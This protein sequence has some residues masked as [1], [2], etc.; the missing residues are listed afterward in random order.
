MQVPII[1]VVVVAVV[2]TVGGIARRYGLPAPLI[3]T[4][5]GIAVSYLPFVGRIELS[6]DLVLVGL[7]A[8]LLYAASL[9]TSLVDFR[10]N[11]RPI[12]LL[13]VGLVLFTAVG[14]GLVVWWL[15]PVSLPAAIAV[16]AVVAPPDAVAATAI[17]RR[18]GMP[19]R[20]VTILEGESLVNDATA[21][22]VLRTA[23]AAITGTV[24]LFDVA[25][26]FV[27][28]AAGGFLVGMLVAVVVCRIRR[29]VTDTL[30]DTSISLVTPFATYLVAEEIHASGI[31]AVVVTGLLMGHKAPVVQTAASRIFERTIWSAIQFVLENTVFLLIGLQAWWITEDLAR[32]SL[33]TGRIVLAS[34]AVLVA[35]MVLRPV[36][37]FPAT[38]LARLVPAVARRDPSP[39]WQAPAVISWAGLRGVVTLA[40]V[41]ALPEQTEHR[42]VLVLLALV[43]TAGT[44]LLQ[45]STLP[46]LVRRLGLSAPDPAED[47]LRE[48]ELLQRAASV[49]LTRLDQIVGSDDPEEIV[50]R[51]RS[52]SLERA[53]AAWERLAHAN[54]TETPAR[55]Y[56][57]LRLEMLRAERDEVLRARD[58]GEAPHEVL[59]HVLAALDIEES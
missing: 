2:I 57:R 21:I 6:T 19:R 33:S 15:L 47:A 30:T 34:A 38:Y 59:Q 14:V 11:A 43:V 18:V 17:A 22:V 29:H 52:R 46:W 5:F 50:A 9:R 27:V 56:A 55:S 4:A 26:D 35:V 49:G 31:L 16:G 44:L 12:A 25:I 51:L 54:T 53:N 3:L 20:I 24:T 13:S 40:A 48:A 7:L 41:F 42:E 58:A 28:S 32:T 8:P 36:W 1:V 23:I 45:G 37:V 39:P 10:A